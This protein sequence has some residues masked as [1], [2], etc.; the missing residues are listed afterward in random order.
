MTEKSHVSIQ[1]EQC[2][3]CLE[4]HEPGILLDRRMRDSLERVTF[5]G[6]S[7]CP[8]C[9]E[10]L[11]DGFVALIEIDQSPSGN[12]GKPSEATYSGRHAFLK[13]SVALDLFDIE[14]EQFNFCDGQVLDT[15]EQMSDRA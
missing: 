4:M 5:T 1:Q 8:T 14:P 3:I 7:P 12:T 2:P 6:H 10:K 15:L 11:D 9:K 13:K